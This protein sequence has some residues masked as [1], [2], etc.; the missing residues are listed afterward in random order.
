MSCC[1]N[2]LS[3]T[4]PFNRR[5]WNAAFVLEIGTLIHKLNLFKMILMFIKNYTHFWSTVIYFYWF[6]DLICFICVCNMNAAFSESRRASII[7]YN[8][9]ERWRTHNVNKALIQTCKQFNDNVSDFNIFFIEMLTIFEENV[10][11]FDEIDFVKV[12]RDLNIG[13]VIDLS[14][15]MRRVLFLKQ[16]Y[17]IHLWTQSNKTNKL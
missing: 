2:S 5:F 9:A 17:N 1:Q 6:I 13:R 8:F 10:L 16:N 12:A 15:V 11:I 7:S 3:L 14:P 4:E